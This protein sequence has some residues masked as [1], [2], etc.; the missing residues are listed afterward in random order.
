MNLYSLHSNP[1]SLKHHE[2]SKEK[3][4][5]IAWAAA[6][7]HDA[8]RRLEKLWPKDPTCAYDYA[9]LVLKAPF[10]AGE[11]AIAKIIGYAF[12]Y[13]LNIL[14]GRFPAAERVFALDPKYAYFYAL[15]II[16]GRFPAGEP[17]IAEGK[18][19][20]LYALRVLKDKEPNTWAARYKKA[21]GL[22]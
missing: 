11:P 18:F 13:A 21:H 5:S 4:P 3:I 9:R 16:K 19:A 8:K 1:S 10:P 12:P 7:T 15:K 20:A 6:K 22:S 14:K 2:A 17:S